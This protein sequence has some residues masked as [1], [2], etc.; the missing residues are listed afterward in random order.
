MSSSSI[1]VRI[2]GFGFAYCEFCCG[3]SVR[4]LCHF[5]RQLKSEVFAIVSVD[6]GMSAQISAQ[7]LPARF[8][9]IDRMFKAE[10]APN[11]DHM[12]LH[13]LHLHDR[14]IKIEVDVPQSD[15]INCRDTFE[16]VAVFKVGSAA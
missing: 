2:W 9:L 4:F 10:D 12:Q 16:Q 13:S 14:F 1:C 5:L 3:G 11:T 7:R 15:L 8:V 6:I